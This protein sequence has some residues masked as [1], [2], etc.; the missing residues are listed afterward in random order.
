[1]TVVSLGKCTRLFS[2]PLLQFG[3]SIFQRSLPP[4]SKVQFEQNFSA[5]S[6]FNSMAHFVGQQPHRHHPYRTASTRQLVHAGFV[7]EHPERKDPFHL[8]LLPSFN[9]ALAWRNNLEGPL[10][11]ELGLLVYLSVMLEL[12]NINHLLGTLLNEAGLKRKAWQQD[13]W[14]DRQCFANNSSS[15]PIPQ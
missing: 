6:A 11:C 14:L 3:R 7:R 2:V 13:L 9:T 5:C 10:P 15:G 12:S 4:L 1:M 8:G